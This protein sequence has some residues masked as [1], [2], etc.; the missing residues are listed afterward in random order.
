MN[1]GPRPGLAS[2]DFV[3]VAVGVPAMK[4]SPRKWPF[5]LANLGG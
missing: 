1:I 3:P 2:C 4:A 5:L